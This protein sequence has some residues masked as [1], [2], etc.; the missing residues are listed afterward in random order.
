MTQAA[1]GPAVPVYVVQVAE[2][3]ENGGQF[4]GEA[5]LV[6][7]PVYGY[8]DTTTP[9]D[10]P[11][12]GGPS[13][14]VRV[15]RDADLVENGGRYRLL[16]APAAMPIYEVD[17]TLPVQGG[18]ALVVYAVNYIP[19]SPDLYLFRDL[20]TTNQPA[21]LG[22]TRNTQPGPGQ[23]SLVQLDGSFS[24]VNQKLVFP[25]QTTPTV[26]D[27]YGASITTFTRVA[28]RAILAEYLRDS[29]TG[30]SF[31]GWLASSGGA[32]ANIESRAMLWSAALVSAINA[33]GNAPG[34]T[35]APFVGGVAYQIGLI[36]RGAG[37]F[38]VVKGGVYAGWTLIWPDK[39]GTTVTL[40]VGFSNTNGSGTIDN[41]RVVD[42]PAPW[43]SD[44]GICVFRSASVSSGATATGQANGWVAVD[45]TA[46]AGETMEVSYRR[47]DDNNC[48]KTRCIKNSNVV[49]TIEVN[50]GVE[51]QRDSDAQTWT[52][53]TIYT[54]TTLFDG[55]SISNFVL[56]G[57][58]VA[59]RNTA[60]TTFNQSA[61]G[62]KV[63]GG[64]ALAN[65][66]FYPR[67]VDAY[68]PTTL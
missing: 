15:I 18:P 49:R 64:V 38:L 37:I 66:E 24:I 58:T 22:A 8:D 29:T 21:P 9:L 33:A 7:I 16:G 1:G 5:G 10:R 3:V 62:C 53:S 48:L 39:A 52:T 61:T 46:A 60:S 41:Y 44:F 55:S 50:A 26:G 30:A 68:M 19:P 42:L 35:L 59:A 67:N 23:W 40:R 36:L 12:Q 17:R 56:S 45:W 54:V 11:V 31:I 43:T 6:A 27:Q 28:G 57:T 4:V 25:T 34:L 65:F 14:P 20:F 63:T 2:F 51:T 47:T 13:V 32:F